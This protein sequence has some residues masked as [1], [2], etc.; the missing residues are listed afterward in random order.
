MVIFTVV[1]VD[2]YVL[3]VCCIST[4]LKYL[5]FALQVSAHHVVGCIEM[6]RFGWSCSYVYTCSLWRFALYSLAS[7]L[8]FLPMIPWTDS[9]DVAIIEIVSIWF[10]VCR[11]R[12]ELDSHRYI[13]VL[14]VFRTN[15][16]ACVKRALALCHVFEK[17]I[18][19]VCHESWWDHFFLIILSKQ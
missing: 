15:H 17:E 9:L 14:H 16:R 5:V 10:F 18:A 12:I 2:C 1:G 11:R 19:V 7:S 6:S 8:F 3:P 4:R 13:Q